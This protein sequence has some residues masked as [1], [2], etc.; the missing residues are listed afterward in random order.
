MS[1]RLRL[2]VDNGVVL[3]WPAL[4]AS[5]EIEVRL[6]A[7]ILGTFKPRAHW[8]KGTAF[9]RQRL[10]EIERIIET[11]H[12]GACDTDDGELYLDVAL[13]HLV[14]LPVGAFPTS[15]VLLWAWTLC[16]RLVE[17]RGRE[18][19]TAREAELRARP[20][21]ARMKADTI[22]VL[23]GI[24]DEERRRLKLRTI[25]AVDRSAAQRKADAK[26][27][28]RDRMRRV[29]AK[30]WLERQAPKAPSISSLKPWEAE[31]ISRSGWYAKRRL[32]AS[33]PD[34]GQPLCAIPSS[35]S[36]AQPPVQHG[37]SDPVTGAP[38]EGDPRPSAGARAA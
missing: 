17:E 7:C 20:R 4:P 16:P 19:F 15:P 27:A 9:V 22:A 30:Q 5:G 25:G 18:W 36:T 29:R 32:L 3:E 21:P 2:V 35:N 28:H 1:N 26:V 8:R 34:V 37:A 12:G 13:P 14:A 10:A 24:R 6:G 33:S 38:V 11:R 23:L 31:G